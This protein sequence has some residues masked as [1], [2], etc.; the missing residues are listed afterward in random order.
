[1]KFESRRIEVILL[2]HKTL[3]EHI[4]SEQLTDFVK[5]DVKDYYTWS[6]KVGY[7]NDLLDAGVIAYV[8][9]QVAG[10]SLVNE[11][12]PKQINKQIKKQKGRVSY[13]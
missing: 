1:M 5:S 3:A 2:L 13:G 7:H 4:C 8:G 6:L 9:G 11:I 10:A 12:S